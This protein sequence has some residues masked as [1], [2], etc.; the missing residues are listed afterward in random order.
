M[1]YIIVDVEATC[2]EHRTK[3]REMEIIEIGAV[4]LDGHY[5]TVRE[6]DSFVRPV[7]NP[8][9]S[10]FCTQ[11]TKIQQENIDGA[12]HF[13]EALERFL[14]W[15]GPDRYMFCS[16]GDYDL[17]QFKADCK[18]HHVRLPK[19]FEKHLN[20]KGLFAEQRRIRPLGF[21]AALQMMR[22]TQT[23]THHRGVDDA[24]NIAE[25]ARRILPRLGQ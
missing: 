25:I 21:A 19:P 3:V 6:F 5:K 2:W 18:R 24:R 11:L 13:P 8:V 4:L 9:L 12:P 1:N 23:G 10:A 22:I 17:E 15:I 20:L 14:T 7:G 16:W